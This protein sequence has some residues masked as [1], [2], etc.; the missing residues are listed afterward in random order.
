MLG[1]VFGMDA[2][3]YLIVLHYY[4]NAI[5]Y[6]VIGLLIPL[7]LGRSMRGR[8]IGLSRTAGERRGAVAH[9]ASM[10]FRRQRSWR[11]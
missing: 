5:G 7:L 10:W 11:G 4:D 1:A 9:E 2:L 6:A 3:H 8:L